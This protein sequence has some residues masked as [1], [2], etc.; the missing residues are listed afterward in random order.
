MLDLLVI[1][2]GLAGLSAAIVVA[3][4]GLRVRVVTKGL[5]ALHWAAGTI[6]LLGYLPPPVAGDD[7]GD[8]VRV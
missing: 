6:D 1:G 5:S 3:E 8:D 7:A 4:A 2:A